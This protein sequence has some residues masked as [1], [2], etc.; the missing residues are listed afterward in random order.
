MTIFKKFNTN[1][2]THIILSARQIVLYISASIYVHMYVCNIWIGFRR[3]IRLYSYRDLHMLQFEHIRRN[4]TCAF[5]V[6]KICNDPLFVVGPRSYII[7]TTVSIFDR[8][9]AVERSPQ[10]TKSDKW[11]FQTRNSNSAKGERSSVP[12]S[13]S[14]SYDWP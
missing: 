1:V 3:E 10:Y 12:F 11:R 8:N 6:R 13:T 4:L 7:H 14:V 9:F 2:H 5:D